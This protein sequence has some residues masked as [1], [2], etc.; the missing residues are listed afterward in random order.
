MSQILI[1]EDEPRIAAF[2]AKGLRAAGYATQVEAS[3][4]AARQ[5]ALSGEF[6]LIILDIG[7]PD[8]DGFE[9]LDRI[10]ARASAFR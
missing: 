3:G 10:A 2:I 1:V 5:L 8:I 4:V 9:V 6:D 7:L